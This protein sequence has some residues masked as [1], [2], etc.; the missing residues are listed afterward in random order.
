MKYGARDTSAR[1]GEELRT[2]QQSERPDGPKRTQRS[3]DGQIE[4][5][6]KRGDPSKGFRIRTTATQDQETDVA[7]RTQAPK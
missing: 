1:N 4:T 7:R 3:K 5:R 2:F 6:Q